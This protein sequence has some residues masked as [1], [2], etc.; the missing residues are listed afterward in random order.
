VTG[1]VEHL[2]RKHEALSP[3]PRTIKREGGGRKET[4]NPI[5]WAKY[6]EKHLTKENTQEKH[7]KRCSILFVIKEKP[8]KTTVSHTTQ[9]L[10]YARVETGMPGAGE[11][12]EPQALTK[13]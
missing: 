5:K 10:G 8:G 2:S 6:L 13:A 3:I 7:M 11:G 1:L 12:A 4:N 9:T